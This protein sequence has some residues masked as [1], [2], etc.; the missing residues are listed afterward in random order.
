ML[1]FVD[2]NAKQDRTVLRVSHP[3]RPN[4]LRGNA[5][6]IGTHAV[7]GD[8][9]P[10]IRGRSDRKLLAAGLISLTYL[11]ADQQVVAGGKVRQRPTRKSGAKKTGKGKAKNVEGIDQQLDQLE[12]QLSQPE[13]TSK[14]G[15]LGEDQIRKEVADAQSHEALQAAGET[16]EADEDSSSVAERTGLHETLQEGSDGK[17]E[18]PAE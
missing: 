7:A 1:N 2:K 5:L 18:E 3:C 11:T 12:Q 6:S 17:A 4:F 14:D 9:R 13:T 8:I 16:G 15:E 10:Y